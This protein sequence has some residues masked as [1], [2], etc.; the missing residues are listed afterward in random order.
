MKG[1]INF[2]ADDTLRYK[3]IMENMVY[4]CELQAKNVFLYLYAFDPKDEYALNIYNGSY[5]D[6]GF[7]AQMS[8]LGVEKFDIVVM[9]PPY[10]DDV[11]NVRGTGHTLWDKFVMKA[12]ETSLVG[13]GYLVAVH[14][15][16]WRS[17]GKGTFD[18]VKNVLK[19]K[20]MLYLEIH[21]KYEGMKTF[22]ASTTYDFYCVR[23]TENL[24]NFNTK[25]KC[26]DGTTERVDISKLS[27]IPNG[28]YDAFKKLM[29]K[30]GEETVTLIHSESAYAHRKLHVSKIQSEEFKYPVVYLTYKNG[31]AK[32]MYSNIITNGHYNT[33]K[34]IWSNGISTPIVDSNGEYGMSEYCS[35]IVDDIQNLER[36]K[37]AM[38]TPEFI[39]LMSFS[40]GVTGCG[41]RYNRKVIATFRKDFWVD[42]L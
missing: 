17:I 15:D 26:A 21:D 1:L 30:K 37:Q 8:E 38:L 20:Q 7:D 4:V 32:Y 28:M 42:F 10:Q 11:N 36:I 35:A 14:P 22:G 23:N 3:H 19:N 6:K 29:P 13:D 2:E 12:L 24:G 27:F 5:L 25:I 40:D 18:K 9:N 31:S 33:P 41:H 39:K 16:G 34:V